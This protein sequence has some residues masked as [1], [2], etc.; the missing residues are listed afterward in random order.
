MPMPGQGGPPP[1]PAYGPPLV[2]G[3]K[4]HAH[5][6]QMLHVRGRVTPRGLGR[7]VQTPMPGRHVRTPCPNAVPGRHV[8][9]P[10]PNAGPVRRVQ[11]P[12]PGRHVQMPVAGCL[13]G[14]VEAKF[15]GG[16]APKKIGARNAGPQ[17]TPRGPSP[18][19]EDSGVLHKDGAQPLSRH[20]PCPLGRPSCGVPNP[21]PP[22]HWMPSRGALTPRYPLRTPRDGALTPGT[23]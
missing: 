9:T 23:P 18:A 13:G 19:P 17:R 1:L 16:G 14:G 6:G 11:T 7:H 4:V 15:G 3:H 2:P 12:M 21:Q 8:Q 10:C 22:P 20:P 5:G